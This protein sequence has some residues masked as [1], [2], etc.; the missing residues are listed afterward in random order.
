MKFYLFLR[1]IVWTAVL[2][3]VFI[4]ATLIAAFTNLD[5]VLPFGLTAI[6]FAVLAPRKEL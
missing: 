3:V 4:I 6:A 1:S 2:S 5:L